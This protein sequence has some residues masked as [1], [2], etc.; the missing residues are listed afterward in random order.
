MAKKEE[1]QCGDQFDTS[2]C[3]LKKGHGGNKHRDDSE[4]SEHYMWTTDG[5]AQELATRAHREECSQGF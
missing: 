2:H 3:T 1:E 5:K 4:N